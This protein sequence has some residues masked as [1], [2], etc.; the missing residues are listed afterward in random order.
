MSSELDRYLAS[1]A[2]QGLFQEEGEF[3]IAAEKALEKLSRFALPGPGLW[4]VKMLQ[5]AVCAGAPSIEFTF[6][7]RRVS[8]KFE[9]VEKWDAEALLH[10]MMGVA[11]P[12]QPARRHLFAGIL[13]AALGFSQEIT[14]TCGGS[15]AHVNKSGAQSKPVDPGFDFK[16]TATRPWRPAIKSGI[17]SSPIRHLVRQTVQEFTALVEHGSV[18][19]IPV[20]IDNRPWPSSYITAVDRLPAKPGFDSEKPT[21][22]QVLLAQIPLHG[23]D[24]P[25]VHYPIDSALLTGL[26]EWKEDFQSICLS[27]DP[28]RP[29][30]G[31]LCLYWCLQRE[32]R[33]NLMLDGVCLKRSILFEDPDL[34]RLKDVL[35]PDFVLDIYLEIDWDDLDLSQFAVRESSYAESVMKAIPALCESLEALR[36]ECHKPDWTLRKGPPE[37]P[38]QPLSVGGLMG[39]GFLSLFI[40]HLIVIGSVVGTAYLGYKTVTAMGVGSEWL[41]NRRTSAHKKKVEEFQERL[42]DVLVG[43][44]ELEPP[45]FSRPA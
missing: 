43:L 29:V 3:R 24:R 39:M 45:S 11:L 42:S 41:E 23:L 40:P 7:R 35:G 15:Q 16:F 26:D 18:A 27:P 34:R 21:G 36:R 44:R 4:V 28:D 2:A 19:P 37:T 1:E 17:I 9:N 38:G 20:L 12:S 25:R 33:L 14:W 22:E 10:Q 13:G 31:V 30:E 8:V 32:S 6:E 5:A